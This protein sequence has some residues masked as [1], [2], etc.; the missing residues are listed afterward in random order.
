VAEYEICVKGRLTPPLTASF[1]G[2]QAAVH[3]GDTTFTGPIPD[4]AA[5]HGLLD[6]VAGLGLELVTVRRLAEG[7]RPP[8]TGRP[9]AA[10]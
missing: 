8:G 3:A 2:M 9:G 7:E 4:Q 1:E 5:L 6:R 10:P